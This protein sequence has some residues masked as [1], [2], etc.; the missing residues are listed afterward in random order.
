MQRVPEEA[1]SRVLWSIHSRPNQRQRPNP[2]DLEGDF[3]F[4]FDG[5]ACRVVTGS[6][7]YHFQGGTTAHVAVLPQL[8]IQIRFPTGE[9]V[10][11]SQSS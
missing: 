7:T 2:G 5:G 8:L 11:I 9:T 10:R 4:W 1:V 6:S 3:D